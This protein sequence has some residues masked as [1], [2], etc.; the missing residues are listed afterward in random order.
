[1]IAVGTHVGR[2]VIAEMRKSQ[3]D[4][5]S[6]YV[7]I[8]FAVGTES[9]DFYGSLSEKRIERGKSAGQRIGDLTCETLVNLGWSGTWN[10]L[11][12]ELR[13]IESSI[14][15]DHETD[16]SG[17]TRAKVKFVNPIGGGAPV[18]P[19]DIAKVNNSF[20]ATILAAKNKRPADR[21]PTRAP[22]STPSSNESYGG[23][24]YEGDDDIPF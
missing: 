18:E 23:D 1:M 3:K 9:V 13:N 10:A 22:S 7:F 5:A 17:K 12:A 4:G 15:V 11:D 21:Q 16:E 6:P 19:A 2:I 8:K 20:K 14:V 24:R